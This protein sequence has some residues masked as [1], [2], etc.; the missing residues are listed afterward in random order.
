MPDHVPDRT[1]RR[2]AVNTGGGDAPGLNAVIR[3]VVLAALQRGWEVYGIENGYAGLLEG[4][5]GEVVALT[6]DRVRGIT[7]LGGTILGTTSRG[8]PFEWPVVSD[9]EVVERRDRSDEVVDAFRDRG[10]DCLVA[11]GGDGSLRLA[12]RLS[13]KG[14]PVVGVPKTIDNDVAGTDFT[15]GFHTAVETATEAID[16]VH[17]TAEAHDRVMVVEVMGRDAG[18]IAL[19][20]GLAGTADVILIPEIPFRIEAVC[21]KVRE[22]ERR[23]RRFAVACV[24]EGA[25]RVGRREAVT[26]E[27]PS[28]EVTQTR[29]G[30]IGQV[31][32]EQ[33][34]ERTD[35]E[36]RSVVLGHLQRGGAPSPY[37]RHIALRFGAAAVRCIADGHLG[38]M[39]GLREDGITHLPLEEALEHKKYVSPE[40]DVVRTARELGI[41]FGD[42]EV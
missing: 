16:K 30:G 4:E 39:V 15:F 11:I 37:D 17:S 38:C 6:R 20:S 9:G 1:T 10:F 36:T 21:E 40:G 5:E 33:I 34:A 29:L 3:S 7:F 41:A 32:A 8:D 12:E 18:W 31:V 27:V 13:R 2:I 23:G 22:R 28:G 24:A 26:K 14:I 42:E 25:R 35:K 19:Y